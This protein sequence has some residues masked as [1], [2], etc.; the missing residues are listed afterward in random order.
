MKF[1]I[2]QDQSN[3]QIQE[4]CRTQV[5]MSNFKIQTPSPL[6]STLP[7][8]IIAKKVMVRGIHKKSIHC[9]VNFMI[10]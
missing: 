6:A 9:F 4:H 8:K 5:Q 7:A 2:W 1:A 3:V 10:I